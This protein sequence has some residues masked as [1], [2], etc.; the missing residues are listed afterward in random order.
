MTNE[1][2]EFYVINDLVTVQEAVA[3]GVPSEF[4]IGTAEILST[5]EFV[6]SAGRV[7]RIREVMVTLNDGT[8]FRHYSTMCSFSEAASLGIGRQVMEAFKQVIDENR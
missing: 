4:A 5:R 3:L 8:K 2:R 1:V 7:A 6:Y